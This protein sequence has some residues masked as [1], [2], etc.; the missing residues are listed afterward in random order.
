MGKWTRSCVVAC[1]VATGVSVAP[2]SV[3]AGEANGYGWNDFGD[4]LWYYG[5]SG[6]GGDQQAVAAFGLNYPGSCLLTTLEGSDFHFTVTVQKAGNITDW[7]DLIRCFEMEYEGQLLATDAIDLN[8]Y[9]E[10]GYGLWLSLEPGFIPRTFP[11][12]DVSARQLG[13]SQI[14]AIVLIL[15]NFGEMGSDFAVSRGTFTD[16]QNL[17]FVVG[18]ENSVEGTETGLSWTFDVDI[19]QCGKYSGPDIDIE[20]YRRMAEEADLPSTR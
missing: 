17:V 15:K 7:D 16:V 5:P 11:C 2:A 10:A 14:G 1:L 8:D 4:G 20:H 13:S 18:L 19:R 9:F 6:E 3:N 12:L